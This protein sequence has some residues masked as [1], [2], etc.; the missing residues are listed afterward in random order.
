MLKKKKDF[1]VSVEVHTTVCLE[2]RGQLLGSVLSGE[3][4]AGE[5]PHPRSDGITI[6]NV[7]HFY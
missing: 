1:V 7:Q 3:A 5:S 2:I 6:E 4:K